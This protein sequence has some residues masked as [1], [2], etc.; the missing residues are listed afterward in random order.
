MEWRVAELQWDTVDPQRYGWFWPVGEQQ[1]NTG[2]PLRSEGVGVRWSIDVS[3]FMRR[4]VS[5]NGGG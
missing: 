4:G 1:W 3:V 5:V 2:H